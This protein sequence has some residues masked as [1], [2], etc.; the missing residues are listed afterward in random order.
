MLV[1]ATSVL[2][3]ISSVHAADSNV[4]PWAMSGNVGLTSDYRYRGLSNSDNK[5]SLQAEVRGDH[6]AGFYAALFAASV[7]LD[8]GTSLETDYILGYSLPLTERST[9]DFNY[10]Y[11]DYPGADRAAD[12]EYEEWGVDY[13]LA[14]TF[15]QDDSFSLSFKYSPDYSGKTGQAYYYGL[16]YALPVLEQWSLIAELGYTE[17]KSREHLA[18]AFAADGSQKGYV[19]YKV[20]LATQIVGLDLEMAWVDSNLKT[21]SDTADGTAVISVSK[22]F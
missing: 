4:S 1:A 9:L 2:C 7:D 18:M 12:A 21:Q 11:F 10:S 8:I 15:K 3:S 17:M 14:N 20:A 6:S 16:G 19:D 13:A 5:P 22:A